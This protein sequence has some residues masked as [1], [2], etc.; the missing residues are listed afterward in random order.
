[1]IP[2][3]SEC[4]AH[5]YAKSVLSYVVTHHPHLI[6]A[7]LAKIVDRLSQ[8]RHSQDYRSVLWHGNPHYFS[9]AQ[10]LIIKTLWEAYLNQTPRVGSRHLLLSADMMSDKI[11]DLFKGHS[12]WKDML[13][14]D[15]K[16]VYWLADP[17]G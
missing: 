5:T 17:E 3:H 16:G 13:R 7:P 9:P 4:H 2:I 12:S 11:S 1:M 8:V 6:D 15:S 10:S 14:T